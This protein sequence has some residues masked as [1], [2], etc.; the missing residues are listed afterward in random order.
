MCNIE[1]MQIE[2]S[3]PSSWEAVRRRVP[4]REIL[5]LLR[6]E[7]DPVLR[8]RYVEV[9]ASA[10]NTA[11]LLRSRELLPE[12][13]ERLRPALTVLVLAR[14]GAWREAQAVA[15]AYVQP[16]G[17]DRLAMEGGCLLGYYGSMVERE[18]EEHRMA[19]RM[20]GMAT[21]LGFALGLSSRG[22]ALKGETLRS[23]T[24]LGVGDPDALR[25]LLADPELSP[26]QARAT[27]LSLA[28]SLGAYGEYQEALAVVST[29]ESE[30]SQGMTAFYSALLGRAWNDPGPEKTDDWLRLARALASYEIG[31]FSVE[32]LAGITHEPQATYAR[33]MMGAAVLRGQQPVQAALTV[34]QKPPRP[35]DQR[36]LWVVARLGILANGGEIEGAAQL[37]NVWRSALS[38]LRS[39]APLIRVLS[40]QTPETLWLLAHLRGAPDEL[41][42][43]REQ[44]SVVRGLQVTVGR[45]S[46]RGA[47]RAGA[48]LIA[49]AAGL[50]DAAAALLNSQLRGNE[51]KRLTTRYEEL[52]LTTIPFN[53]G[54]SLRA[55]LKIRQDARVAGVNDPEL[56]E[57]PE[58]LIAGL[59]HDA[60]ELIYAA[61]EEV[62]T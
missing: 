53:P 36:A 27:T 47:G 55:A 40:T 59:T 58:L 49:D 39:I 41:I 16:R 32:G 9:L 37:V 19:E 14:L 18:L 17:L 50:G 10:G 44:A 61:F 35:H 12:I 23:A 60:R 34:R 28:E 1:R 5:N 48:L 38:G 24:L 26:V 11:D 30:R 45:Q 4:A 43:W 3:D 54:P 42:V 8:G 62:A 52:G 13:D 57:L 15:R 29:G 25:Q 6:D 7:R 46:F 51:A 22:M 20:L 33:L 2:A 56:E 31:G 21:A